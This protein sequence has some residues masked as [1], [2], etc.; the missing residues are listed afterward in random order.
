MVLTKTP[1]CN[2]EEKAYNFNLKGVDNKTYKLIKAKNRQYDFYSFE[3]G[4]IRW[5][6]IGNVQKANTSILEQLERKYPNIS[7]LFLNVLE[8]SREE[9]LNTKTIPTDPIT[10]IN[11]KLQYR[12]W[13]NDAPV[14]YKPSEATQKELN[15]LTEEKII[16]SSNPDSNT[17]DIPPTGG[18]GY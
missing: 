2:F 14:L 16:L 15:K 9:P 4:Y 1:I 6:L 8:Y 12:G 17:S 18:G 5:A 11:T 3:A 13:H 10:K 7:N